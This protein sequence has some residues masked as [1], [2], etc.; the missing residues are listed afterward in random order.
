MEQFNYYGLFLDQME[1]ER[2]LKH[3]FSNY[4]EIIKR[5][6]SDFITMYLDHCTLL[7]NSQCNEKVKSFCDIHKNEKFNITITD[8]GFSNKAIA[9]KID[10]DSIP[11]ANKTPHITIATFEEGKPVDSNNIKY[12]T[13]I[14]PITITTTL[15]KV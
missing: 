2:V 7:H 10:L 11:C 5:R 3:I 14:E 12:W 4:Y 13:P 1:K 9:L 15:K 6:N 8:I